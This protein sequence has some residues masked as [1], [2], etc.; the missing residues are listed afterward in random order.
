MDR[1]SE[2]GVFVNMSVMTA[3]KVLHVRREANRYPR[4]MSLKALKM[5]AT[6][7][8]VL[9]LAGTFRAERWNVNVGTKMKLRVAGRLGALLL[10]QGLGPTEAVDIV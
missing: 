2:E 1:P 4:S 5:R 3:W 6:M 7:L 8:V 9:M 10:I